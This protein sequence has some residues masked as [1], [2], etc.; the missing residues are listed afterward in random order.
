MKHGP[1]LLLLI[2]LTPSADGVLEGIPVSTTFPSIS[3]GYT[4]ILSM[5]AKCKLI[6]VAGLLNR[7]V[8]KCK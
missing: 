1:L 8:V 4:G 2:L 5:S 6:Y 3:G 7:L